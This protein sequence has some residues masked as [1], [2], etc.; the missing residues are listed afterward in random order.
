MMDRDFT[1]H[2]ESLA[3]RLRDFP[4]AAWKELWQAILTIEKKF[5]LGE[6]PS[7]EDLHDIEEGRK[8]YARGDY[9]TLEDL[10]KEAGP[11]PAIDWD[12]AGKEELASA[13]KEVKKLSGEEQGDIADMIFALLDTES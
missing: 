8:A 11:A 6:T 7:E 5:D 12:A 10:L 9:V 2:I 4:A 1:H 13:I 3:Y